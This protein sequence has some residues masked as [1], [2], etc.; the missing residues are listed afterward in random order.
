MIEVGMNKKKL[1]QQILNN[2]KNVK[3]NDFV[4]ILEAFGFNR[5]RSEGSH[6]IYRNE[7]VTEIINIQN[8]NGEAKPYQ[9]KQFFSLVEKYNLRMEEK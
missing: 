8:V 9:I 1:F 5:S 2:Q 4:V 6:S 7:A 3:Y